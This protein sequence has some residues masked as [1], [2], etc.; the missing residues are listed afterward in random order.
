V[1]VE[2]AKRVGALARKHAKESEELGKLAEPVVEVLHGEGLLGMWTPRTLRGG[3]ELDPVTSLEVIESV[4]YGDPSAGWVLMAAS[5][6]IGT[7]AAY[8]KDEAVKEL[9]GGA[10]LPVI[11][12]QGTR[13]G[14][15]KPAKAAST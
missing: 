2:R 15:A 4:S 5:L 9:F 8:L 11:A 10:R 12:G 7:G 3:L 1:F 13:P 14:I 6:A